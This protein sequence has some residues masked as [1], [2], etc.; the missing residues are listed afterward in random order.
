MLVRTVLSEQKGI[1]QQ[2]TG[3]K[4]IAFMNNLI[5]CWQLAT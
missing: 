1:Y 5:L 3:A 4:L 2:I